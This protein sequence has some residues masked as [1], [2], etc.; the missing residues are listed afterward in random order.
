MDTSYIQNQTLTNKK[1][2][3]FVSQNEM[4]Q[5][6]TTNEPLQIRVVKSAV[7]ARRPI[8]FGITESDPIR[9]KPHVFSG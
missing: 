4:H 9:L 3:W 8:T 6:T 2:N 1:K 5:H 7:L